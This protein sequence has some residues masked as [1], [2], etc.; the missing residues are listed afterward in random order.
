[1][2]P[3]KPPIS[4][5]GC[6]QGGRRQASPERVYVRCPLARTISRPS[7]VCTFAGSP[8]GNLRPIR[9]AS[10]ADRTSSCTTPV[11][12]GS[13]SGAV[14]VKLT[15]T[16][17]GGQGRSAAAVARAVVAYLDGA[18]KDP[19]GGVVGAAGMAAYLA[20][21]PEGPG[22]WFGAGATFHGLDGAVDREAFQRVLEGR[23]RSL[24]S[25]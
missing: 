13:E 14:P 25:G 20:D 21:S 24:G 11:F 6:G 3:G 12:V 4:E 23:I 19:A 15:V 5:V 18:A 2:S 17:I 9:S 8:A 10:G 16:P 22:R 7:G 1:M